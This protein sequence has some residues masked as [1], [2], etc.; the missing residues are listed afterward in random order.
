MIATIPESPPAWLRVLAVT[1]AVLGGLLSAFLLAITIDFD[2]SEY[3]VGRKYVSEHGDQYRIFAEVSPG[4]SSIDAPYRQNLFDAATP[5]DKLILRGYGLNSI[6]RAGKTVA[7]E[8][9]NDVL[10][11]VVFVVC[12]F[13]PLLLLRRF[14]S[15]WIRGICYT[16]GG[17]LASA[18][19]LYTILGLFAPL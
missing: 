11:P 14:R 17:L 18:I 2:T 1:S 12:A 16:I 10:I 13:L 15:A 5:G 3:I 8:I 19:T 4:G 7:W 9:S 6:L